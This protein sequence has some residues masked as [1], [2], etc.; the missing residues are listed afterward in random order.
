MTTPTIHAS[1][2]LVGP[3][4]ILIRGPSGSGKSRLALALLQ[5]AD[6]GALPFARLVADDRA[7]VEAVHGR[8]LVRCPAVLAGLIEVR[9]LGLRR[10]CHEPLA[11][12]GLVVDLGAAADRM[13]NQADRTVE[14]AGV[15]LP[16]LEAAAGET[17]LP[18]VLAY[19][20]TLEN[21]G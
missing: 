12:A 14:I 18:A 13:P 16:R 11:V 7:H 6:R 9:G 21:P 8:L 2:V 4:A 17:A 3:R 10:V 1:A 15:R 19:L 20:Q 5:A